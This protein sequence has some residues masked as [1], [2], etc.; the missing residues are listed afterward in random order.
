M[1]L[2]K[3]R[4]FAALS[5]VLIGSSALAQTD[6]LRVATYNLLKFSNLSANRIPFFRTVL[7]AIDPDIL[8][9]QEL[10]SQGAQMTFL[11]EVLNFEHADVYQRSPFVNGPDTDN[12]LY[13]KKER[14]T[15]VGN[16]QIK[17]DLRDFSEYTLSAGTLEFKIVSVHLKAGQELDNEN[18]RF[19]EATI[20]RKHLDRLPANSNF[21]VAGDFNLSS[22]SELAFQELTG[23]EMDNDGRLWDPL[24]AIGTWH[25]NPLFATLHTQSTRDSVFDDGSSGGLD[26]R[27]D[28]LLISKSLSV[29]ESMFLLPET[30]TAFGNDGRHFNL[31]IIDRINTA[32]PDSVARALYFASDHLPVYADFV[33]DRVTTVATFDGQQPPSG[34]VLN[35]N[36]PN[37]FNAATRITYSVAVPSHVVLRIYDVKGRTIRKLVDEDTLPGDYGI[38]WDGKNEADEDVASGVY[39]YKLKTEGA[40]T[41]MQ[42]VLLR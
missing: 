38:V 27:Y 15:L 5:L 17:T 36:Y 37:P 39:F 25:N 1:Q 28:L 14:V 12:S 19:N 16:S 40:A 13:Y 3:A 32:V 18:Q 9:V 7:R 6:T 31:A 41:V 20:L 29:Q 33:V 24:D 10:D 21:I 23:S 35:Q 22:S 34:F 8:V 11:N 42:M 30:Y 2:N 26:D 4:I